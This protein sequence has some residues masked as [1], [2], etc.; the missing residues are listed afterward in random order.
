[1]EFLFGFDFQKGTMNSYVTR[2]LT[3]RGIDYYYYLD[4][5]FADL[6]NTGTYYA[7]YIEDVVGVRKEVYYDPDEKRKERTEQLMGKSERAI[8][9]DKNISYDVKVY[10]ENGDFFL[11]KMTGSSQDI[12]RALIGRQYDMGKKG[13]Q[14]VVR[15][16]IVS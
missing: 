2:F 1:M 16:E 7:L 9:I 10:L 13:I 8:M 11:K 15:A 5:I 3:S 12:R 4:H 6:F 14:R